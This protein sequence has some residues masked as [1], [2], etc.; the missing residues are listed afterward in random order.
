MLLRNLVVTAAVRDSALA[1]VA[2]VSSVSRFKPIRRNIT[3]KPT[4]MSFV[5]G[6]FEPFRPLDQMC[7]PK[8]P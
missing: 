8:S 3:N 1:F 4:G 2:F 7:V 5:L 6:L